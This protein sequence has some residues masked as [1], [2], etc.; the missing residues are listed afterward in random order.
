MKWLKLFSAV[1]RIGNNGGPSLLK[2]AQHRHPLPAIMTHQNM[3]QSVYFL[4]WNISSRLIYFNHLETSP[5][6]VKELLCYTIT[7][8]KRVIIEWALRRLWFGTPVTQCFNEDP[9]ITIP[10]PKSWQ[11]RLRYRGGNL[12]MT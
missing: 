11:N 7:D 6:S 10:L 9:L 1:L 8:L 3:Y 12:S 2:I 5:V 4:V